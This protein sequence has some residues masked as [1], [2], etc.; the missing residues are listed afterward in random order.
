MDCESAVKE[1]ERGNPKSYEFSLLHKCSV[2]L[3]NLPIPS[4][5]GNPKS[6]PGAVLIQLLLALI[7][8]QWTQPNTATHTGTEQALLRAQQGVILGKIRSSRP[9]DGAPGLGPQELQVSFHRSKVLHQYKEGAFSPHTLVLKEKNAEG[10]DA[11]DGGRGRT[12]LAPR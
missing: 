8:L 5:E 3:D 9:G 1:A 12:W 2:C 10:N 4:R 7:R 6:I 11:G